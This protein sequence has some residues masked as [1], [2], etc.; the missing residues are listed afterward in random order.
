MCTVSFIARERGYLLGMNRDEQIMR[1]AGLPPAERVVDG[2]TVVAPREP[3]GGTWIAVTEVGMT[4]ALINWYSVQARVRGET[5]SR[6]QVVLAASAT[7]AIEAA[8]ER[9]EKLPL[10]KINPFRLIG[11]F[12]ASQ[13]VFE[14]RWDLRTL[15]EKS[16]DWETQQWISSGFDEPKA[17]EVRSRIF[18]AA[19][20]QRTFGTIGWLRRLHASHG[21]ECGP[22][23]TC[24]HRGDAA[25]VSY[26]EV[27]VSSRQAVM[28]YR[29]K[30]PCEGARFAT[31]RFQIRKYASQRP[32]N[33]H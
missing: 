6:G 32:F 31:R 20:K 7:S 28:R 3:N 24:M 26:T 29:A 33:A 10:E 9:L 11:I 17:Q 30:S 5:I 2:I 19:Q 27:A 25:T 13:E 16:S 14:W 18:R 23:S 4:F 1:V 15:S 22:F 8:R 12:P 21:P